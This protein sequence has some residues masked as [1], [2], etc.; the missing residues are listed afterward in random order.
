M[1]RQRRPLGSIGVLLAV[2]MVVVAIG[3]VCVLAVFTL[4][5]A[6]S[7]MSQVER[8]QQDR[9]ASDIE[10][11]VS[12]AYHAAGSWQ[13][14]HLRTA[15][16]LADNSGARL[17]VLD[18]SGRDVSLPSIGA[19]SVSGAPEGPVSTFAVN[20]HGE[21][22][23]TTIVHFYR[24]NLPSAD[25]HLRNGLVRTVTAGAAVAA[26]LALAVAV[27]LSRRITRPIAALTNAVRSM[28]EGD[29]RVRVAQSRGDGELA[30]LAE[31]FNKM[32]DTIARE[33]DLRR[34][35]VADVA[36][37]LRT[38]LSILQA[39]SESLADGTIEPS[40]RNLWSLHEEVLRLG[41]IVE[42]LD[43]LASA[44]AA[45]LRLELRAVDLSDVADHAIEALT[46]SYTTQGVRLESDLSPSKALA[47]PDRAD[48]IL[49]NLL[50][51]ALKF[52]APGGTVTVSVSP[53]A[54]GAVVEVSDTGVGI[55]PDELPHVFERFWRGKQ[56]GRVAGSGIGLAV[57]HTLVEAHGGTIT[58]DSKPTEGTRFVIRFVRPDPSGESRQAPAGQLSTSPQLARPRR[59]APSGDREASVPAS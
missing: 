38:P 7:D 49:K 56:T 12:D 10:D 42:D 51:N 24:A 23:G 11:T 36:H 48:Q 26:F 47:D 32:A 39:G 17:I 53:E 52:T 3:A 46:P 55:P 20:S 33:D 25:T 30:D 50:S 41:R 43:T 22:V 9:S 45:V 44:E 15:A 34:A 57:V 31:A 4:I 29:R 2:A 37:E 8:Q 40:R 58:V 21:R 35:V 6:K 16:V 59:L 18:A 5:A 27:V 19:G 14:A 1:A 13:L 54:D 28:G